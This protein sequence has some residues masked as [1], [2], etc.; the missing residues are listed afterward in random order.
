MVGRTPEATVLAF[1]GEMACEV[2]EAGLEI[3]APDNEETGGRAMEAMD[4]Q[5]QSPWFQGV[6]AVNGRADRRNTESGWGE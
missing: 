6:Y 3:L 1:G 5:P 2:H 4:V